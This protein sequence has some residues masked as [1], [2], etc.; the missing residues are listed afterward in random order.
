MSK[1][2]H[3]IPRLPEFKMAD[4]CS[5]DFQTCM[6][7]RIVISYEGEVILDLIR[8]EEK[9]TNNKSEA[10]CWNVIESNIHI[11][12]QYKKGKYVRNGLISGVLNV[13]G[14]VFPRVLIEV[15]VTDNVGYSADMFYTRVIRYLITYHGKLYDCE[16]INDPRRLETLGDVLAVMGG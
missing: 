6:M 16:C 2:N 11:P 13:L 14:K 15:V 12:N 8:P 4:L 3:S 9:V 7:K 10:I 5:H 1:E